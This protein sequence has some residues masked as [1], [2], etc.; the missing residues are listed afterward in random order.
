MSNELYSFP[1]SSFLKCKTRDYYRM[2][3]SN[4]KELKKVLSALGINLEPKLFSISEL[5]AIKKT[6]KIF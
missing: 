1:S 5:K 2:F 4:V 6:I 3:H